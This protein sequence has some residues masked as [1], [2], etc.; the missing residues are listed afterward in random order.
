[1]IRI[2]ILALIFAAGPAAAQTSRAIGF[3]DTI[4]HG[5][6]ART[7]RV[8]VPPS[9]K[10]SPAL[11][12]SLHG[13][14]G[15]AHQQERSSGF[16]AVAEEEG[17]VAVYPEGIEK[18]WND[19][20]GLAG[21]AAQARNIDDVG[22]LVALIDHVVK[23]RGADPARVFV[24]GISNGGLMTMRLACERPERVAGIGVVARSLTKS[25]AAACPNGAAVP[26]MFFHGTEDPLVPFQGGIQNMGLFAPGVP[27]LSAA[28]TAAFWAR[29]NGITSAPSASPISDS[30]PEDGCAGGVKSV[31]EGASPKQRV[32][33]YA[34]TGGGHT[35]PRGH[36]G[37]APSV[38]GRSCQDVH[39][40]RDMWAFFKGL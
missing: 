2:A 11:V 14:G 32:I 23:T 28:D 13:R 3:E 29:R 12:L 18:S 25:L 21:Y 7:A 17:F 6:I 27:V 37:L 22:F 40:T 31:Y 24:T 9:V 38:I 10:P 15:L 26:A 33:L 8:F 19:G 4:Q 20:R 36:N 1:M 16:D 30:V 35:W 5:G 34:L 39:A